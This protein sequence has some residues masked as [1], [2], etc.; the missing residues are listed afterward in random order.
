LN[1]C[2]HLDAERLADLQRALATGSLFERKT[3]ALALAACPEPRA[4]KSFAAAPDLAAA[5]QLG[6]LIRGHP[7]Q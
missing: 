7:G 1:L 5:L 3:A 2:C 6:E 4:K